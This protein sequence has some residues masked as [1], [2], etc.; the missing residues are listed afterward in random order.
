MQFL[1]RFSGNGCGDISSE[2]KRSGVAGASGS[3]HGPGKEH[4][5]EAGDK[6]ERSGTLNTAQRVCVQSHQI[7]MTISKMVA[8]ETRDILVIASFLF[9]VFHQ[10]FCFIFPSALI[11]MME[12]PS[13]GHGPGG[14]GGGGCGTGIVA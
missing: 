11:S 5:E 7:A 1:L 14:V 10:S 2:Q 3:H 4:D 9:H 13:L 8:P 12:Y 6:S